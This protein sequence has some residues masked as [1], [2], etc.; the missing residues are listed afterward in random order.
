MLNLHYFAIFQIVFMVF[1]LAYTLGCLVMSELES[2]TDIGE[3]FAKDFNQIQFKQTIDKTA[4]LLIIWIFMAIAVKRLE[5]TEN[6]IKKQHSKK[7]K[8]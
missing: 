4:S 8:S 3:Q 2:T 1:I 7:I 6:M 5:R